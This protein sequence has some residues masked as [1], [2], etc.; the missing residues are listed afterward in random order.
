MAGGAMAG[1]LPLPPLQ[2]VPVIGPGVRHR[3]IVDA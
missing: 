2:H 3:A 1:L